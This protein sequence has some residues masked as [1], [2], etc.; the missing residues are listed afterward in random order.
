MAAKTQEGN[1]YSLKVTLLVTLDVKN[2]FNSVRWSDVLKA[3]DGFRLPQYLIQIIRS[4]LSQRTLQYDTKEGTQERDLTAGIAQGSILGPDL[5]NITYDS[6]LRLDMPEDT[7]LIGYADDIA[8]VIVGR[9]AEMAQTA[10]NIAMRRI[11]GWMND[12]SL[13]LAD[14]KTEIVVLTRKKIETI[15]PFNI[16]HTEITSSRS[17]K[18]LGVTIDTKLTFWDHIS[19]MTE[20]AA[21]ITA[22]LS[23]LMANTKGPSECK[24]RLLMTTVHSILL[25][26][27]EIWARSLTMGKYRRR[28]EAVQRRGAL[29]IA[30]SYR[31]VSH[32]AVIL[33][34]S[35]PPID[36]LA[37]ERQQVWR[38]RDELGGSKAKEVA[39]RDLLEKWQ[40]RWSGDERGRWTARLIPRVKEWYERKHGEVNYYLTQFL[41]GH[42]NFRAYLH[43]M[44]KV[45]DPGC[46]YC[47]ECPD[48]AAHTFFEC[49]RWQS[50][51]EAL[52]TQIG[53]PISPDNIVGM[54]TNS[55]EHW[56]RIATFV[57]YVLRT[58]KRE[59]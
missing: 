27:A 51:R 14:Q 47:G 31:T 45:E 19:K 43:R 10:L 49:E 29:R 18:Y 16:N 50:E 11:R 15:I 52:E 41:T 12:H 39:R 8:L 53:S 37:L 56:Q 34:A 28:L 46:V 40:H 55:K 42:G 32:P 3:I 33:V 22:A 23:R 1:P 35:V 58:K 24:R 54:M 17:I 6:I 38:T 2:A 4:Y 30:C 57:E 44:G 36:L 48:N 59:G 26:G 21:K 13:S 7:K 9:N 20:K 25:Y 5:W